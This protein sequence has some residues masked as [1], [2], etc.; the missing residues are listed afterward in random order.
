MRASEALEAS[1]APTLP[2]G[3][4]LESGEPEESAAPQT[5]TQSRDSAPALEEESDV[6]LDRALE[7][8]KRGTIF[9]RFTQ[10]PAARDRAALPGGLGVVGLDTVRL[11]L[12]R[13]VRVAHLGVPLLLH[14]KRLRRINA[15]I[16]TAG[17]TA[18]SSFPY[19]HS[20]PRRTR[21]RRASL[22]VRRGS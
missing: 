2:L 5:A 8:L 10:G 22:G 15:T 21:R 11:D 14:A 6:Q 4:D 7:V 1:A 16:R 18:S 12:P 13:G 20:D 19:Q 3:R 17:R 9:E